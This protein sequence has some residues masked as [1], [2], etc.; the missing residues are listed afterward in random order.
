[1]TD[2]RPMAERAVAGVAVAVLAFGGV[3]CARAQPTDRPNRPGGPVLG[4]AVVGLALRTDPYRDD[5]RALLG[6]EDEL[7]R[8]CM[9][10]RGFDYPVRSDFSPYEDN[11]WRP[12]LNVRHARGYGFSESG[13]SSDDQY[14]PG[15]PAAKRADYARALTGDPDRRATLRL[16]TG[17]EFTFATTG[18]IAESRISLFGDVT[19]A[20]KVSYVPQEA[21][22]AIHGRIADDPAMRQAMQRWRSCMKD[23][24]FSFTSMEGSRAAAR[25]SYDVAENEDAARRSEIRIAV[26]DGECAQAADLPGTVDQAGRRYVL[27]LSADLRRDLNAAAKLRFEALKR[28]RDIH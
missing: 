8:R 9:A 6:A 20:A 2:M 5:Q 23:R 22:N 19:S 28:V 11:S 4:D 18:C 3:G 15:L 7:T 12:D 10:G 13:P 14:P 24:G 1:M 21:Y 16:S 27:E 17:P 25:R 26:A